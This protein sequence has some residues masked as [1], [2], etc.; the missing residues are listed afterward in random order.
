LVPT[1]FE[2]SAESVVAALLGG[3]A[4][5]LSAKELDRIGRMIAKV[6]KEST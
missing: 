6:R 5:R 4:A 2:E 1:F 3:Q